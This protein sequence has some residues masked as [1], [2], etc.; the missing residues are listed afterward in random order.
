[1]AY[2]Q[3]DQVP[4]HYAGPTIQ[5]VKDYRLKNGKRSLCPTLLE[6][7][8]LQVLIPRHFGFC[9][10]VERAIH[11]AFSAVKENLGRN[12]YLVSE[13]I[14]NPLVNNDPQTARHPLHLRLRREPPSLRGRT[15]QRRHCAH[16]GLWHHRTDGGL[17]P[18]KRHRH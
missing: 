18:P 15:K 5:R 1:M 6:I 8:Q 16:P 3:F 4:N 11:M 2:P 17:A 10:G 9:F 7:G 12:A 13:I 14:H